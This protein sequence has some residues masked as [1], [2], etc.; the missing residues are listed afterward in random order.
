MENTL[1]PRSGII[2]LKSKFFLIRVVTYFSFLLLPIWIPKTMLASPALQAVA[3][4]LFILFICS[5]W[6]F[7]GKEIDHRLKIYFRVNSSMDRLV[8]RV[9][10]GMFFFIIYFNFLSFLPGKW[11]YNAFWI[12]WA[13]LG[14]FY[15][16]PTRGKIIRETMSSNFSEFRYL[17]SFEKTLVA[18]ILTMLVISIPDLPSINNHEALK[19]FFDPN[20]H[21]SPIYWN[22]LKVNFYPFLRYEELFRLAWSLHFYFVNL[23][24]FLF[25]FYAFLRFILSRRLSLLG[26]FALIS[27]WSWT[28]LLVADFG[29]SLT[30]TY[31]LLWIWS[32][33]WV[34]R[35]STYRTGLFLGL[36]GMYGVLIN[37]MWVLLWVP[38]LALIF[39]FLHDKTNWF[40]RQLFRYASFGLV[41]SLIVVLGTTT[42]N[43][44]VFNF[45]SEYLEEVS[46]IFQRKAFFALSPIGLI[47]T[48]VT[49]KNTRW[50]RLKN[51]KINV[52]YLRYT[53]ISVVIL[54]LF[55]LVTGSGIFNGFSLMWTLTTLSLIPLELI[56]QT[57]SRLRSS[58]NM[59]YLIYILICLLDSHFEGRVKVLLRIF[60]HW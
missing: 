57:L 32:L 25:C 35:S 8:Y 56:F 26:V 49:F 44:S 40:K 58:R 59:I 28:K 4:S 60:D 19:L 41:L 45:N 48:L 5:Q 27:S 1:A 31:S 21:V 30:T 53:G 10:L 11:I 42:R 54:T 16:W 17:D 34:I 6:F 33:L 36:V 18:L 47:L 2:Y 38:H 50:S 3:I 9:F 24:L 43:L 15:S 20:E 14:I 12:T 37:K 51:F 22:F 55:N 52:E 23:G 29:V 39:Y 13:V 7:L 46:S